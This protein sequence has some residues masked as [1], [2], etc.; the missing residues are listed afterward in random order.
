M[1]FYRVLY[2]YCLKDA[3]IFEVGIV[4][5]WNV[6]KVDTSTA[7]FHRRDTNLSCA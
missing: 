4:K 1:V 7:V 3:G 5:P 6:N 2:G